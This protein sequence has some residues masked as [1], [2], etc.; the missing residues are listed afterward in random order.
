MESE[1][2]DLALELDPGTGALTALRSGPDRLP[3]R[4]EVTIVTEGRE[5]RAT[6]GWTTSTPRR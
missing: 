6:A 5:V 3:V 4:V 2:G 1:F